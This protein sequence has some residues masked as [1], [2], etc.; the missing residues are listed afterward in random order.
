M[1]KIALAILICILMVITMARAAYMEVD[2][3]GW[4]NDDRIEIEFEEA[5]EY[6]GPEEYIVIGDTYEVQVEYKDDYSGGWIVMIEYVPDEFGYLYKVLYES[7]MEPMNMGELGI[8]I[9]ELVKE[10]LKML[11]E[12]EPC[13]AERL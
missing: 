12:K 3:F 13:A 9:D 8:K 1:K 4:E 6:F 5:T 11:D 10:G 2:I 7:G